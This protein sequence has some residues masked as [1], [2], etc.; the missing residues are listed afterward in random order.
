[1]TNYGLPTAVAD[2][3]P[4]KF[5]PLRV[6]SGYWKNSHV[7][8]EVPVLYFPQEMKVGA[9]GTKSNATQLVRLSKTSRKDVNERS[10]H[11]RFRWDGFAFPDKIEAIIFN[12]CWQWSSNPADS[13]GFAFYIDSSKGLRLWV[14]ST[15]DKS[16]GECAPT[17]DDYFYLTEGKWY[18]LAFSIKPVLCDDGKERTRVR[19]RLASETDKVE[20]VQDKTHFFDPA[21]NM[22]QNDSYIIIGGQ[23]STQPTTWSSYTGSGNSLK[24]FKGAIAKLKLYSR[25]MSDDELLGLIAEQGGAQ[26]MIGSKNGSSDEFGSDPTDEFDPA[27][28]SWGNLRKELTAENPSITIRTKMATSDVNLQKSL[29]FEPLMND[30]ESAIVALKVNGTFIESLS[31]ANGRPG[32]F[33]IPAAAWTPD[34]EGNVSVTLSRTLGTAETIGIDSL[35]LSG[36]WQVGYNDGQDAEFVKNETMAPADFFV[37]DTDISNHVRVAVYSDKK[38]TSPHR[39]RIRFHVDERVADNA[40]AKFEVKL[41]NKNADEAETPVKIFLNDACIKQVNV[42]KTSRIT[43]D[44]PYGT[45][46][47]GLNCIEVRNCSEKETVWMKFDY[48]RLE[49]NRLRRPFAVMVR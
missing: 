7:T 18:D 5:I 8:N 42:W 36:G 16:N 1:V 28:H 48:F 40:S 45:M 26:W 34:A 31:L 37:G 29:R 15:K 11:I 20:T 14:H 25:A 12:D 9:D 49:F 13:R 39:S 19:L 47:D 24:V 21:L 43:A 30:G 2:Q 38:P 32:T 27:R 22:N 17:S 46:N 3:E 4:I 23:N 41:A 6:P 10:G 35:S 33:V 44:I